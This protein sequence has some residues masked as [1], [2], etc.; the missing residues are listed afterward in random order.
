MTARPQFVGLA[1]IIA[2]LAT[3]SAAAGQDGDD[4][5]DP[6]TPPTA[7]ERE[8]AELKTELEILTTQ[9]ALREA[10]VTATPASGIEGK[11]EVAEGA[12]TAEVMALAARQFRTLAG[13]IATGALAKA[14]QVSSPNDRSDQVPGVPAAVAVSD[15]CA[16]PTA[17]NASGPTAA[18]MMSQPVLLS[19]G[20]T[21]PDLSAAEAFEIR[22]RGLTRLICEAVSSR[23]TVSRLTRTSTSL[24]PYLSAQILSLQP[25]LI[26]E[27]AAGDLSI[28]PG[29]GP[30]AN[31]V[32]GL[33]IASSVLS[34]FAADFRVSGTPSSGLDDAALATAVLEAGNGQIGVL[35]TTSISASVRES[36]IGD[37]EALDTLRDE[38]EPERRICVAFRADMERR[39]E[40][41][42]AAA[43]AGIRAG[44]TERLDACGPI[45][46]AVLAHAAFAEEF[47]GSTEAATRTA[48]VLQ[49]RS[50]REQLTGR[51]LLIV[52]LTGSSG[53]AYTQQN[54]FSQIGLMPFHITTTSVAGWQTF[55][56]SGGFVAGGLI[57]V[58]DGYRRLQDVDTYINE[59]RSVRNLRRPSRDCPTASS[60]TSSID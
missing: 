15:P 24:S 3:A 40:A 22:R 51:H 58:Y 23:P 30:A 11:V 48:T 9:N 50:I 42:D 41:A 34:Y 19:T 45:E 7:R 16:A 37:L 54:L 33:R 21:F 12:G 49:Q 38:V 13:R 1:A 28:L 17:L 35:Q 2:A 26:P 6:A 29:M 20:S 10:S 47:G 53:S 8:L 32:S 46:R 43:R 55:D 44:Y 36:F 14:P 18:P 60:A 39:V 27:S 52:D 56:G 57:P 59:C 25:S 4:A 5:P 31:L